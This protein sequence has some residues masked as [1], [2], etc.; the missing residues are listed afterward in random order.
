MGSGDGVLVG[1]DGVIGGVSEDEA[2][3]KPSM[4][5]MSRKVVNYYFIWLVHHL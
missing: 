2:R 5:E 3:M 4:A 1:V